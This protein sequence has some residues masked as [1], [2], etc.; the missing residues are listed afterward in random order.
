MKFKPYREKLKTMIR[1]INSRLPPD[2]K[3]LSIKSFDGIETFLK[4]NAKENIENN[5]K[6]LEQEISFAKL[7][8]YCVGMMALS[9]SQNNSEE[10]VLKLEW[11][12]H[13]NGLDPNAIFQTQVIEIANYAVSILR[14]VQEGLDSPARSL[15]RVMTELT[16]QT[17]VTLS[18]KEEMLLYIA[19]STSKEANET[20]IKQF[21]RGRLSKKLSLLE[22]RLGF[23]DEIIKLMHSERQDYFELFSQ[24]VHNSFITALVGSHTFPYDD[25]ESHIALYGGTTNSVGTPLGQLNFNLWHFIVFL[26][27]L[28]QKIHDVDIESLKSAPWL[29]VWAIYFI[30]SDLYMELYHPES[31]P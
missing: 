14:L 12:A 29:D 9:V 27:S 11:L 23:D 20:W 7:G 10:N 26:I 30:L 2:S 22:E 24:S 13:P 25:E 15:V 17:L 4:M 21:G 19:P 16:Q 5:T 3:K 28:I 8:I 31:A 18:S 1:F 6:Q